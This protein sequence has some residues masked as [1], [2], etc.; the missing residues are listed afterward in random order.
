VSF[1]TIDLCLRSLRQESNSF[2]SSEGIFEA[3]S[4]LSQVETLF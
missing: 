3:I 2:R 1:S 4:T